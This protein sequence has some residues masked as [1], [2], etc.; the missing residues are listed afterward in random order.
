MENA[1]EKNM[2]VRTNQGIVSGK[3]TGR[4]IEFLGVPYGKAERFQEARLYSWNGVLACTEFG[5]KAPQNPTE[6]QAW[7]ESERDVAFGEDC[8]NLNIYTPDLEGNLPVLV[9]IHGGAF[10]EGSNQDHTPDNVVG[11]KDFV[12]INLNYRLGI[13]GYLYLGKILG[14]E[15]Q[16]SGNNGL[17]DQLLALRWV[18]ENIRFFGGDPNKVTVMGASAGAKSI[19]T[20]MLFP[21]SRVYFSQAILSSGAYQSIRNEE[22]AQEVTEQYLELLQGKDS[23]KILTTNTE[24]LLAVQ[25][26]LCSQPGSTCIFGPVADGV[27]I[28]YD[29]EK[30][31]HSDKYWFG[32]V[33]IG[34]CRNELCF[35]IYLDPDFLVHAPQMA[36]GL[37]GLNTKIAV[38]DYGDLCKRAENLEKKCSEDMKTDFWVQVLS[39]YMYRMYSQKLAKIMIKNES[40]VYKYSMEYPPAFHCQDQFFAF[41][42]KDGAKMYQDEEGREERSRLGHMIFEAYTNFILTGDP[43][44]VNVPWWPLYREGE[45]MRMR[46]DSKSRAEKE[47]EKDTLENF[48]E[49]VY[50]LNKLRRKR[51][52]YH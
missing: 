27:K 41:E 13:F 25:K 45:Y 34:S 49:Q 24:E 12:Y 40:V 16:S 9:D 6:F 47:P 43:N 38:K 23:S 5:K 2:V 37:F 46:W 7:S 52:N 28:P 11:N 20:L 3:K 51:W 17:T 42:M 10:Q 30:R 26:E 33:I 22:T 1:D 35:H 44:G 48:P 36:E 31:L 39:D 19:A 15:Y 14:N 4:F 50:R 21:D 32:R 8:L 18:H 29:W